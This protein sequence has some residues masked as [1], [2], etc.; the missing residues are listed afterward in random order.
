M[1]ASPPPPDW[2]E[3]VLP[4]LFWIGVA[5]APIAA[6]LLLL[7]QGGSP[8]RIAAVLTL[9]C[10]VLIG[11]SVALRNDVETVRVEVEATVLDEADAIREETRE[12]M[13]AVARKIHYALR[14]EIAELSGRVDEIRSEAAHNRH[15]AAPNPQP[16][17]AVGRGVVH[18]AETGRATARPTGVSDE[19]T[20]NRRAANTGR[21]EPAAASQ[22]WSARTPA[23]R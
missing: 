19:P 11:L 7:G 5:L 16:E 18:R 3:Q 22:S 8:L 12:D 1:P 13:V 17:P 10:V 2:R 4:A 20:L 6:L 14:E 9:V 21:A 15:R 23:T